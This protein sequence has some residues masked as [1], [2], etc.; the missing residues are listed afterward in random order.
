MIFQEVYNALYYAK[1]TKKNKPHCIIANTKKGNGLDY[2]IDKPLM[3]GYMP[4]GD[5]IAKA[6]KELR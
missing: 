5:E 4:K 2:L 1:M 3:H 6:F